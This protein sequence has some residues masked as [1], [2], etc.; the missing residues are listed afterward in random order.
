[1]EEQKYTLRLPQTVHNK[2][3]SKKSTTTGELDSAIQDVFAE[4]E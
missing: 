3:D 1:M 4:E 2:Y